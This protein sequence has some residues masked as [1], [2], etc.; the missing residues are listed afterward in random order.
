MSIVQLVKSVI[1]SGKNALKALVTFFNRFLTFFNFG[2]KNGEIDNYSFYQK[3]LHNRST[4]SAEFYAL[5]ESL[6]NPLPF[7]TSHIITPFL[8]SR[9]SANKVKGLGF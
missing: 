5:L 1:Q 2:V 7:Y 4:N 9:I 6:P 3:L 8:N